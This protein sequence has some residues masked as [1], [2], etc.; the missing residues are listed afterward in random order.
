[1]IALSGCAEMGAVAEAYGN[2]TGD[3][4]L[5]GAGSSL[6]RS[7]EVE[8]FSEDE[9]V[10][11]G[12]SVA[13]NLLASAQL[14]DRS[15]QEAYVN[16]VGQTLALAS[17]KASLP[18]GWHFILIKDPQVGAFSVPGGTILV[19]E[20]LVDLCQDEDE[21]AGVLAHEVAH[22][23]LDHPM[24]AVSA[25]NRKAALLG[26]AQFAYAKAAQGNDQLSGLSGQFQNVLGEVGEA[27]NHGY[28]QGKE[29][30]ADLEAVRI[31]GEV[32]YDPL[33]LARV[34]RRLKSGDRSHGDPAARA[35]AVE[36]AAAGTDVNADAQAKRKARFVAAR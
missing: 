31:L 19:D 9:K 32:G 11:T 6:K 3:K 28:D 5:A 34:L 24:Q 10:Y 21:L 35:A 26:L 16:Q 12:R 4:T 18:K 7:A 8:D 13:A 30:A 33:G 15:G 17:G 29:H 23:A 22:I 36:Q 20:G 14:S 1:M 25:S 2:A 27:V